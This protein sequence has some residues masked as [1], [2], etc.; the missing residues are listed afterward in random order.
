MKPTSVHGIV[1]IKQGVSSSYNEDQRVNPSSSSFAIAT[2]T[3]GSI[4]DM[5]VGE[6]RLTL[7]YYDRPTTTIEPS[8]IIEWQVVT[9]IYKRKG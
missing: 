6:A 3:L 9:K 1:Y 2:R 4:D 8:I 5:Y 7:H